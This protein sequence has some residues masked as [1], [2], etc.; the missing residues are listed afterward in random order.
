MILIVARLITFKVQKNSGNYGDFAA[1]GI[2]TIQ[3]CTHIHLNKACRVEKK[4]VIFLT[5]KFSF[6]TFKCL[7]AR[8][9]YLETTS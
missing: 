5:Q 6:I 2:C 7:K 1:G 3:V 4:L 8:F 9:Y